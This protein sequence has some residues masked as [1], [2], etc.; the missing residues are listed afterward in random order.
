MAVD[1]LPGGHCPSGYTHGT[2][3]LCFL[4]ISSTPTSSTTTTQ[5][6]NTGNGGTTGTA[7]G[8][9]AGGTG[10]S[11]TPVDCT[12]NPDACP[13]P[14][15]KL[16]RNKDG[17]CPSGYHPVPATALTL[18]PCEKNTSSTPSQLPTQTG[19]P[20]GGSGTGTP[21]TTGNPTTPTTTT[22]T[23]PPPTTTTTTTNVINGGGSSSGGGGTTGGGTTTAAPSQGSNTF[24]T[25]INSINKITIKYPSTWTK[26][27]LVGNPRIPVMF[28]AP[29]TTAAATTPNTAAAKT[30]FVISISPS[31][32]NLDSF[33]QQQLNALTQSKAVKYTITDTN[34]K[35]LTPP[36][37]ITA[38]R[39]VSYDA[40]KN[41]ISSGGSNVATSIPL[42]GAA[43]FF[44]NGS[45]GYSL[46]YLAKQIE[47]TQNLPMV[48]QMVNSFQVGST[49]AANTGG[50]VQNVAAAS[51]NTR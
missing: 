42:K 5:T 45:T 1:E 4:G 30:S 12:K 50:P 37:G 9:P 31:A 41:S 26:T 22:A 23:K 46:L 17:T 8:T 11:M 34:S 35:V 36:T 24:L 49:G 32:S 39:E 29:T 20:P 14:P 15:L 7:G 19:N 2:G 43:I 3:L 38:F 18:P 27:D 16:P 48:Q 21:T 25:Y 51:S 10:T 13:P 44:V 33:A 6:G 28:S 40:M 47:Y